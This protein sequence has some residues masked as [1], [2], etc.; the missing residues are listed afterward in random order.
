MTQRSGLT[1]LGIVAF[2][3]FCIIAMID[4]I[5]TLHR[6]RPLGQRIASWSR[7]YPLFTAAMALIFG[8]MLGHFFWP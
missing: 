7:R 1:I 3:L 6:Q 4:L 5:L 8:A 2:G